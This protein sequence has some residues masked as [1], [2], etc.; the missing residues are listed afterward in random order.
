[1]ENPDNLIKKC[2]IMTVFENLEIGG[3]VFDEFIFVS[4]HDSDF[5]KICMNNN[6]MNCYNIDGDKRIFKMG[7][8]NKTN[9]IKILVPEGTKL[10]FNVSYSDFLNKCMD[11][12]NEA[13]IISKDSLVDIYTAEVLGSDEYTGK[14]YF[15]NNYPIN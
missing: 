6:N 3:S 10:L 8:S 13:F 15:Y 11:Y 4:N 1:M 9:I 2:D 7:K 5:L 12:F 14:I